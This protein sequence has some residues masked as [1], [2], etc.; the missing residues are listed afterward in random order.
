[1]NVNVPEGGGGGYRGVA[2]VAPEG[3]SRRDSDWSLSLDEF[4]L[5]AD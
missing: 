3:P 1:M 4:Q 2:R 5:S